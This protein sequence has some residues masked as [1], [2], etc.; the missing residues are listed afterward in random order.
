MYN[1]NI[2]CIKFSNILAYFYALDTFIEIR[3]AV[4]WLA[5]ESGWAWRKRTNICNG[6]LCRGIIIFG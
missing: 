2:W 4:T 1:I 6:K 5:T 3:R